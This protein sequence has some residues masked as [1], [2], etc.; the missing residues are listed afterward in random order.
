M[1][2]NISLNTLLTNLAR[3][4]NDENVNY[5]LEYAL[6]FTESEEFSKFIE[7]LFKECTLDNFTDEF[8]TTFKPIVPIKNVYFRHFKNL[9]DGSEIF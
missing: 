4:N 5:E 6:K 9:S 1:N 8:I 7:I 2:S 3:K